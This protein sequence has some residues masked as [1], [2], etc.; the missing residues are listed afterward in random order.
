MVAA[1]S[2]VGVGEGEGVAVG[3]GGGLGVGVAVVVAVQAASMRTNAIDIADKKN[4][5]ITSLQKR[6]Y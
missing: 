2:S 5:L 1:G 3:V 6:Y 4:G